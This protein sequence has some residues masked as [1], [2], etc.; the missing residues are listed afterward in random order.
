MFDLALQTLA[1]VRNF[2]KIFLEYL[3]WVKIVSGKFDVDCDE[4]IVLHQTSHSLTDGLLT[5]F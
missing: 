2:S 4:R 3:K 1:L 5:E